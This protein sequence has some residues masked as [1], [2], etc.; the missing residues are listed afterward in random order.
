MNQYL[1]IFLL[2]NEKS[3]TLKDLEH[4]SARYLLVNDYSNIP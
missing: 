2:I 1:Q 3:A 4:I